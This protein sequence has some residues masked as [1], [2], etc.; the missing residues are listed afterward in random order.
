VARGAVFCEIWPSNQFEF[1]T[2]ILNVL[3]IKHMW[4]ANLVI[5][6][7][8]PFCLKTKFGTKN[9]DGKTKTNLNLLERQKI[10]N[11]FFIFFS[12]SELYD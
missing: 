11:C 12:C 2:P 1:E 6:S 5:Q 9:G 8:K 4:P 10:F 3:L 7:G